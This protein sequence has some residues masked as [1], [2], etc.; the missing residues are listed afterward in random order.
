MALKKLV[1]LA[2]F[3]MSSAWADDLPIEVG[4]SV[5]EVQAQ[6]TE[7]QTREEREEEIDE[8]AAAEERRRKSFLA[9]VIVIR[10]EDTKADYTD[11]NVQRNVRS[12]IARPD[13]LF[14]PEVDLYQNGRKIPDTTVIPANQPAVVSDLT[15]NALL[16]AVEQVAAIPDSALSATEW[17]RKG[18]ALMQLADQAWFI[19]RVELREPLFLLYAQIGRVADNQ[20]FPSPPYYEQVGP[21]SVNYHYY[22][23]AQLAY[24][25]PALLSKLTDPN[26]A[27]AV[28]Y[29]YEQ[30]QTGF[31]SP[32][33]L[34]FSQAAGFDLEA[35]SEDYEV[36]LNG[37]PVNL[38]PRGQYDVF[39]GITDIYLS[40]NDTGHGL[41]ERFE[42]IKLDEK[43]YSVLDVARKKMG[44]TFKDQLF[45]YQNECSPEVDG[46][47]L[48]YLAIYQ[49]LHSEAE[50]YIA[51]PENGNPNKVWIWRYD[52]GSTKL[53]QVGGGPDGFP[54]RFVGLISTGIIYNGASFSVST[55][56][57]SDGPLT[58][59]EIFS[60]DR[61]AL[62][63]H[64]NTMPFDI[65][66]RL[67]YNRFMFN[68]G[69]EAGYRTASGEQWV[70][71]YQ[72]PGH[73][74]DDSIWKNDSEYGT[75]DLDTLEPLYNQRTFNRHLYLGMGALLG[76]DAGIGFGPR[77]AA[78]F[79]W[80]NMPHSFQATG[81]VGYAYQPSF[82][83]F[84]G[85]VRPL[86][87][88]DIR[89]GM[90]ILRARSILL[91]PAANPS[92][93]EGKTIMPVFGLNLGAGFTF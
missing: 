78:Q 53:F 61:I 63:Y 69:F 3:S 48:N 45:H 37:L 25:E 50:I 5:S 14:F 55:D 91:D 7:R 18:A 30:L 32:L 21:M 11:E 40:R 16:S 46:D 2:L 20:D 92:D 64:S 79:G 8:A 6:R 31:F 81:H 71:Y 29:L 27:D 52:P 47:I 59:E 66:F 33:K 41:S 90:A 39:P 22:L 49:K 12:R 75:V 51:V 60:D 58:T 35:F 36:L 88:A 65:E 15:P 9:R 24:Q 4:S 85:R 10:W 56:E 68:M 62:E 42:S 80:L 19:D 13:A 57:L 70:E 73:N 86:I 93:T 83:S 54:V 72:T 77:V 28:G 89:T 1:L 67:H 87:D 23:A 82:G 76:R 26:Q 43:I 84:S 17:S 38:D 44:V 74:G 34:D